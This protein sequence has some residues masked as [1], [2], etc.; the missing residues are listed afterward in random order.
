MFVVL[1]LL[2]FALQSHLGNNMRPRPPAT[3]KYREIAEHIG[4]ERRPETFPHILELKDVTLRASMLAYVANCRRS[5][6][7]IVGAETTDMS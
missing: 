3:P 4:I 7:E 2:T 6:Y 1:F 5:L